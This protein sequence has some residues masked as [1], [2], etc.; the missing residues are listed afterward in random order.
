MNAREEF[1]DHVK[2]CAEGRSV[3]CAI[4]SLSDHSE[5]PKYALK[6]NH[7]E[8]DY[9]GF[10][11]SLNFRYDEGYGGQEL[12]GTIWYKDGTWS[13]RGEYDGSEW[14]QHQRCPLIPSELL[15]DLV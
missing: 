3:L 11:N 5:K 10:L 1:L 6:A 8:E 4:V 2:E 9:A 12:E 14:W 15:A 13:D 7:T